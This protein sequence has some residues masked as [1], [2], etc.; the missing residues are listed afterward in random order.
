MG[1]DCRQSSKNLWKVQHLYFGVV[2]SC[3]L[4]SSG[5]NDQDELG[6]YSSRFENSKIPG[7]LLFLTMI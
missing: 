1:V 5:Y 4:L 7:G 6:S 3:Q 2:Q